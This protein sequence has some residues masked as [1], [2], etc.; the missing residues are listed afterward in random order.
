MFGILLHK[1]LQTIHSLIVALFY[2]LFLILRIY[3][4]LHQTLKHIFHLHT[5]QKSL[6]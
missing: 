5:F 1:L 4:S 3:Y 6:K 2:L